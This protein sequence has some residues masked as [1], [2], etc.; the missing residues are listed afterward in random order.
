MQPV[1]STP[2]LPSPQSNNVNSNNNI[3]SR[4]EFTVCIPSQQNLDIATFSIE[5]KKAQRTLKLLNELVK[6]PLNLTKINAL[7]QDGINPNGIQG[8]KPLFQYAWEALRECPLKHEVIEN[9]VNVGCDINP[10][11]N[12][13]Q[14]EDNYSGIVDLLKILYP[15]LSSSAAAI[16][17]KNLKLLTYLQSR[18]K[19][20][21]LHE[22]LEFLTHAI[23]SN[24]IEIAC[25]LV[26]QIPARDLLS[27][28]L[29]LGEPIFNSIIKLN[30]ADLVKK[31]LNLQ[32]FFIWAIKCNNEQAAAI[33]L[34]EN[35]DPQGGFEYAM[36]S[37]EKYIMLCVESSF[38]K[39]SRYC[40]LEFLSLCFILKNAIALRYFIE[41]G[42]LCTSCYMQIF[43]SS[44]LALLEDKSTPFTESALHSTDINKNTLLHYAARWASGPLINILIKSG[45]NVNAVNSDGCTPLFL[46]LSQRITEVDRRASLNLVSGTY[47]PLINNLILAGSD[48]LLAD[49]ITKKTPLELILNSQKNADLISHLLQPLLAAVENHNHAFI[50][51]YVRFANL[52]KQVAISCLEHWEVSELMDTLPFILPRSRVEDICSVKAFLSTDGSSKTI[53]GKI[54]EKFLRDLTSEGFKI[55]PG[56][57]PNDL[58]L[59][60]S[61]NERTVTKKELVSHLLDGMKFGPAVIY[62]A[63]LTPPRPTLVSDTYDLEIIRSKIKETPFDILNYIT[64]KFS[65]KIASR[66]YTQFFAF[67]TTK[68]RGIDVVNKIREHGID[69]GGLGRQL[70]NS[71]FSSLCQQEIL[72]K[73]I[74]GGLYKPHLS[75]EHINETTMNHFRLMGQLFMFCLNTNEKSSYHIQIGQ[76]FHAGIFTFLK[77]PF[78]FS[79]FVIHHFDSSDPYLF[80]E[81]FS[82][83]KTVCSYTESGKK[84]IGHL[85]ECLEANEQSSDDLLLKLFAA[86]EYESEVETAGIQ[87]TAE[88][89]KRSLPLLH[90]VFQKYLFENFIIPEL[91][92]LQ[93]MRRGMSEC[94][95]DQRASF[96]SLCLKDPEVISMSLQGHVDS[97]FITENQIHF[98]NT[99]PLLLRGWIKNW[100]LEANADLLRSFIFATTGSTSLGNN[101]KIMVAIG[102]C[103]SFSSCFLTLKVN[104]EF[105]SSEEFEERLEYALEHVNADGGF[106]LD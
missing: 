81:A 94:H 28:D 96:S 23:E 14:K 105:R 73:Q 5:C 18:C 97:T 20:L 61:T 89:I 91:L 56:T 47:N 75:L 57:N 59:Y 51:E 35:L 49:Y 10:T 84:N 17:L 93:M 101:A 31:V 76:Y 11:L 46:L 83:Y 36:Q 44:N 67:E 55:R 2:L 78:P 90:T 22:H 29:I 39:E 50:K 69:S 74:E 106:S 92:P 16:S 7:I 64:N 24:S 3:V 62:L 41:A 13:L 68:E 27:K 54:N 40:R 100:I 99:I 26:D 33:Y 88:S 25:I 9:L 86:V 6:R 48:L 80:R 79:T 30:N 4:S 95:I 66:L 43:T 1:R 53:S 60:S 104:P 38:M 32:D 42:F 102:S 65:E 8:E 87:S 103:I 19:R 70:I 15:T 77:F 71:L 72:F 45:A 58:I 52:P 34:R 12:L 37:R 63:N 21:T 98:E 85:E 82:L